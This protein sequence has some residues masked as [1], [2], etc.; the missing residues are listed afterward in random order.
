M[1]Q[2]EFKK[3]MFLRELTNTNGCINVILEN[4]AKK[5]IAIHTMKTLPKNKAL[6]ENL[7]GISFLP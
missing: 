7:H 5:L 6:A 2:L 3:K 1:L 4:L